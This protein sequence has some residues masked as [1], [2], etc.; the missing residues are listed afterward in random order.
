MPDGKGGDPRPEPGQRPWVHPSELPS[1]L[2]EEPRRR[3]AIP[4]TA[5]LVGTL[6]VVG[7]GSLAFGSLGTSDSAPPGTS[8]SLTATPTALGGAPVTASLEALTGAVVHVTAWSGPEARYASA[9]VVD[10]EGHVMTA[11][12]VVDG[13]GSVEIESGTGDVYTAEVVGID[14]VNDLALLRVAPSAVRHLALRTRPASH[15]KSGDGCFVVGADSRGEPRAVPGSIAAVDAILRHPGGWMI[16][17]IRVDA[18]AG[19]RA[20]GSAVLAEDGDFI[21]IAV[22]LE[23]VGLVAVPAGEALRAFDAIAAD[24]EV[25]R[26]WLGVRAVDGNEGVEVGGVVPGGPAARAGVRPGDVLVTVAGREIDDVADLM[27]IIRKHDAGDRIAVTVER[28]GE[29]V[30]LSARLSGHV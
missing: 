16:D 9:V 10:E 17:V 25:R 14:R 7:V 3:I 6:A 13:A 2:E 4:L 15:V 11:A 26:A 27:R 8:A 1:G 23:E 24:G 18:P 5:G 29:I 28:D 21:G 12:R 30:E 20:A 22:V 19:G